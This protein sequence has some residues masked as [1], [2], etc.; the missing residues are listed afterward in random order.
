MSRPAR[1]GA[2]LLLSALALTA[3]D[4]REEATAVAAPGDAQSLMLADASARRGAEVFR[5]ECASCHVAGDGFDLAHFGFPD[6]TILRRAVFHVSQQEAEDI[7]AHIERIP[8]DAVGRSTPPF[9]TERAA[10]DVDFAVRLFGEDA[11]PAGV[12]EEELRAIDPSR[13]AAAVDLPLWSDESSNLDWMPDRPLPQAVLDGRDRWV[14][15][16]LGRYRRDATDENALAVSRALRWHYFAEAS[17]HAVCRPEQGGGA[18]PDPLECFEGLRWAAAFGANH[19]LATGGDPGE[20]IEGSTRLP[21]TFWD[22][23]QAARA[24]T[25]HH[26][27]ELENDL[28]NWVS[29]HWVGWIFAPQNHASVYTAG[30]L[31]RTGLR[32]HATFV[33]LRSLVDRRVGSAH[34]AKDLRNAAFHAP[35]PWLWNAV[36][37][38]IGMLEARAGRGEGPSGDEAEVEFAEAL[39]VTEEVLLRRLGAERA[40]PLVERVRALRGV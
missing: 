15:R 4:A 29:W 35:R 5:A 22:V 26:E 33:A 34:P 3:C 32:R 2:G 36:D 37:T 13:I 31:S 18:I 21:D 30:G 23:G 28:E 16:L 17:P 25:L 9:E 39:A 38:G 11:W 6:S 1:A 24:A 14:Q 7:V 20:D 8:A 40:A 12:G 10:D 27:G 19:L